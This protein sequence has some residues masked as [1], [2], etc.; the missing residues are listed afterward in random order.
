MKSHLV[1]VGYIV[2]LRDILLFFFIPLAQIHNIGKFYDE[3]AS[4][5][6][7][8]YFVEVGISKATKLGECI[9]IQSVCVCIQKIL[10]NK[11][12]PNLH[13]I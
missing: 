6:Q 5:D 7:P 8:V 11:Y 12:L 2:H 1:F 3:V 13:I 9:Y 4:W 10:N